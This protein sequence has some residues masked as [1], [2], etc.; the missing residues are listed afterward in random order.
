[1]LQ[2]RDIKSQGHKH[3]YF[4]LL[5]FLFVATSSAVLVFCVAFL[6]KN[7]RR[8][9]FARIALGENITQI[10]SAAMD[11]IQQLFDLSCTVMD[12]AHVLDRL[13]LHLR[14]EG[15]EVVEEYHDK[16][17]NR[18]AALGNYQ[19]SAALGFFIRNTLDAAIPKNIEKRGKHCEALIWYGL[20]V[21]QDAE[22]TKV[23]SK[24][25]DFCLAPRTATLHMNNGREVVAV[26]KD[27]QVFDAFLKQ[28]VVAWR[29]LDNFC[30]LYSYRVYRLYI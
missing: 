26:C 2:L 14:E 12:A 28:R 24:F 17:H 29:F 25:L 15:Y 21:Q 9:A 20:N 10:M 1:M 22:V 4:S 7:C 30:F 3:V 11:E 19:G 18:Y 6:Q 27:V 5:T 13:F 16:Y 8:L 23:V